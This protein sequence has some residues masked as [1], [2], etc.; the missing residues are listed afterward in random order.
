MSGELDAAGNLAN[1]GL[2]AG[3]IEGAEPGEAGEG[4]CLNCG[5]ALNGGRFCSNCGQSAHANRSLW[6]LVEEL[7]WNVFNLDTKAWRTVPRLI[8]R[9]GT[10][11]RSYIE[12]KRARYLTPLAT[13]LLCYFFMFLVFSTV[14]KPETLNLSDTTNAAEHVTDARDELKDAQDGLR[15]AQQ[16]LA[17]VRQG[18]DGPVRQTVLDAAERG[19]AEAQTRV[20][21]RQAALE[22]AQQ[23][24][25]EAAQTP[26]HVHVNGQDAA[27]SRQS[28]ATAAPASP[29]NAPAPASGGAPP[30]PPAVGSPDLN[31]DNGPI[32]LDDLLRKIARDNIQ[33]NGRPWLSPVARAQLANPPLFWNNLKESASRWGFLLVPLSLPF[34]AF[35][36]LFKKGITLYDHTVFALNS[37]SFASLLFALMIGAWVVPWLHWVPGIAIGVVLPVHTFFH[38]GGA[39]KMKWWSAFWR[40]FF[41]LFFASFVIIFFFFAVLFI[42]LAG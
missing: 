8:A 14:P 28:S 11:T 35:L 2:I 30:R 41:M 7:A 25:R 32:T 10:L 26:V 17:E 34:I 6:A 19:L 5:A 16:R 33:I 27:S 13:F 21:R 12:G 15:E 24:Q 23:R 18:S 39:Y 38:I 4:S 1:A 40:S 37:L 31:T 22:R 9:P 29:P 3:A 20:Q 36:F 42:G